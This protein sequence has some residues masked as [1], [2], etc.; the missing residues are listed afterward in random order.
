[1]IRL[2]IGFE[3]DKVKSENV[4]FRFYHWLCLC[5]LL[6]EAILNLD[7]D[8]SVKNVVELIHTLSS[9]ER[10]RCVFLAHV[11]L[12]I[13]SCWIDVKNV[14]ALIIVTCSHSD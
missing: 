2:T 12:D 7:Q 10:F 1:V 8:G 6:P 3:S 13:T 4:L 9:E 5:S 11:S 14:L